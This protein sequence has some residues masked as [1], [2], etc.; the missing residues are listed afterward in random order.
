[1]AKVLSIVPAAPEVESR[2]AGQCLRSLTALYALDQL[3]PQP[4]IPEEEPPIAIRLEET[5]EVKAAVIVVNS[6]VMV[7][8]TTA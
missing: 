6:D 1:M 7:I 8:I 2:S 3:P 4:G 5:F